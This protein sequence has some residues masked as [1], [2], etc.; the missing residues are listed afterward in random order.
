MV[1]PQK[2]RKSTRVKPPS[3]N[4]ELGKINIETP[5]RPSWFGIDWTFNTYDSTV[6]KLLNKIPQPA[7]L[8]FQITR[9]IL[10]AHEQYASGYL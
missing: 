6:V 5:D 1:R 8:M 10:I 4:P 9:C 3:K 2:V 7:V